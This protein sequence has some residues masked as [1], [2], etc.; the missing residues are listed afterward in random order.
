MPGFLLHEN[1][2]VTC[3]HGGIADPTVVSPLVTIMEEAIVLAPT[4][5]EVAGCVMPPP[6]AGNGPCVTAMFVPP[7]ASTL[8]T[9]TGIPVLLVSS[10]ALCVPTGTPL[11]IGATQTLVTGT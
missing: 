7:T 5:Y 11:I 3:A 8:I 6:P 1:A 9:S 2:V 10:Q 4:P